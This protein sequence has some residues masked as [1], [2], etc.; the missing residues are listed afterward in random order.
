MFRDKNKMLYWNWNTY[1][2]ITPYVAL[3]IYF[4]IFQRDGFFLKTRSSVQL[5]FVLMNLI[6]VFLN[7]LLWK[8]LF[9]DYDFL[10]YSL[11]EENG[12]NKTTPLITI[13]ATIVAICGWIFTARVQ[14]IN[15]VK[16]HSMQVLMSSRTSSIYMQK[17]DQTIEIRRNLI[18]E[19]LTATEAE[20][21]V[22][23][24]P[25]KYKALNNEEKSAVVYMLNFLEFV[26]LGIRHYNLDEQLLKASLRSILNSN[27]RL[28]EPIIDHL[29][30][31]D[32]ST[33]YSQVEL[34]HSRWGAGNQIKCL[35]CN[36]WHNP[37][38]EFLP[39][40]VRYNKLIHIL[41]AIISCGIWLIVVV[42]MWVLK[43]FTR[44]GGGSHFYTCNPCIEPN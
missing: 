8:T 36:E 32:N 30:R 1:F 41:L 6:G 39:I 40:R 23:L 11:R 16:G 12:K 25:E 27:Y 26:A 4:L 21:K 22:V 18:E 43:R 31:I 20:K 2:L 44:G 19:K 3:A 17:V 13:L 35:K 29:R 37:P 38:K 7:F 14:I 15:A 33:I 10:G 24:T 34:L 5:L 28:Y 9:I 42:G